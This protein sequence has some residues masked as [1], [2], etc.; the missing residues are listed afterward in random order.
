MRVKDAVGRFGEQVACDH[1]ERAGLT[2]LE[3]NWRCAAGEIDVVALD[4]S[5]LVIVEVKTRSS[6]RFGSPMEAVDRTK[7]LR[8]RRL[9]VQWMAAATEG[10]ARTWTSVRFDVIAV[11]RATGDA[12]LDVVH[13]RGAF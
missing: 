6:A 12:P 10:S 3:R 1:L 11:V 2:I 7:R 5:A 13:V 9:A 8:L 4:G